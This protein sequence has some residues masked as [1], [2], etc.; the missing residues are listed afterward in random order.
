MRAIIGNRKV[1]LPDHSPFPGLVLVHTTMSAR[2][3][4]T[5]SRRRLATTALGLMKER[6]RRVPGILSNDGLGIL[7]GKTSHLIRREKHR[8]DGGAAS[9]VGRVIEDCSAT[10][11]ISGQRVAGASLSH[12]PDTEL[13]LARPNFIFPLDDTCPEALASLVLF[14]GLAV[15]AADEAL[16]ATEIA[17]GVA[18]T[19]V[20]A[21]IVASVLVAAGRHVVRLHERSA[22]FRS[23]SAIDFPEIN[24][25][26]ETEPQAA[27]RTITAAK[28]IGIGVPSKNLRVLWPS[29]TSHA[30]ADLDD[31]ARD[32]Q[33]IVDLFFEDAEPDWPDF[34]R[35]ER[36]ARYL[37]LASAGKISS[38]SLPAPVDGSTSDTKRV[39][40]QIERA[41][42]ARSGVILTRFEATPRSPGSSRLSLS[43][44][45]R[46]P[47][48][49]KISVVGAGE[50]PL[51]MILRQILRDDRIALR[52]ACDRRPEVLYLARQ[53][54]PFEFLTTSYEDLLSDT[55]TD[56]IVVAPYHG[57]HAPLATAAL[58]AGKNC[59][60][61]KPPVVDNQQLGSLVAAAKATDHFLYVGYNRRFAPATATLLRHLEKEEGP[62]TIDIV[63]HSIRLPQNHWYYWPSNGNRIISNTCHFIDYAL[64]LAA[65]ATPLRVSATPSSTG[66]SDA[67]IVIAIEFDDGSIAS[68]TY[69]SRGSNRRSIYYQSY[70]VMKGDTTGQ[71]DDFALLQVHRKGRKLETQRSAVDLGHRQQMGVVAEA[72]VNAAPSPVPLDA[73]ITSATTVLAAAESARQREP[74]P[75]RLSELIPDKSAG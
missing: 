12:P 15:Y 27:P 50:W 26:I 8:L 67:N 16:A 61:E 14:G 2:Q 47:P 13:V 37:K 73:M 28:V 70:Q 4:T 59:F 58:R 45:R 66:R 20:L 25:W 65:P 21:D 11:L 75:I 63:V 40:E 1:T 51:G 31:I 10:P 22:P 35:P 32:G 41:L 53:A 71:I 44:D 5:I 36:M 7:L 23:A 55:D 60:V 34:L 68:I 64:Q 69:T 19:G 57:A 49:K 52:G 54:L 39:K 3:D 43:V 72:L 48:V 9:F 62:V 24:L 38:D 42:H 74:I 46:R 6:A 56:L 33:S 29:A 17:V 18:G 30:A